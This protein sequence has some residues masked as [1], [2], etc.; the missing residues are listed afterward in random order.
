MHCAF[1]ECACVYAHVCEVHV[2]GAGACVMIS[3]CRIGC[4]CA[5]RQ[6][7]VR[8]GQSGRSTPARPAGARARR[9]CSH[10]VLCETVDPPIALQSHAW[11]CCPVTC[12]H[13]RCCNNKRR[14][15]SVGRPRCRCVGAGVGYCCTF[16]CLRSSRQGHGWRLRPSDKRR[17][18]AP[19][20]FV[21]AV[22]VV[23]CHV[24][25]G[26]S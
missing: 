25:R 9:C 22:V 3:C 15:R 13:R 2:C 1:V 12:R 17:A 18:C 19:R 21:C 16:W 5:A 11:P 10:I 14:R 23:S 24:R 7:Q 26:A 4:A 6:V 20:F 8:Y